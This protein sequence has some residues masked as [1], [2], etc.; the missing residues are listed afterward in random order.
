VSTSSP[1]GL[2][3]WRLLSFWAPELPV[4]RVAWLRRVIYPFVI[5]DA[6]FMVTD[7]IP[8]GDVPVAIY[9]PLL[10]RQLLHLPAPSHVYVRVLFLVLVASALVAASGRLPRL[11]GWVCAFAM[12]DWLSNAMSYSKI[13]HDHFALVLTLFVLP[14]VGVARVTHPGRDRRAGWAIRLIQMGV[15]A[16]YALSA[17]AKIRFGGWGWANGA[18]L[19][20]ALT[21]RGS[22]PGPWLASQPPLTHVLQWVVLVAEF[23]SPLMLWLRGR[24]LAAYVLFWVGFHAST[25]VLLKIH[26]LPLAVC[27]LAFAP[28]ERLGDPRAWWAGRPRA[29]SPAARRRPGDGARPPAASEEPSS[30]R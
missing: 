10:V 1:P 26:F 27:L 20:W 22:G 17:C 3:S 24:P 28:L 8:H 2:R 21:R 30:A 11:A 23:C 5:L 12:L 15:V 7:P 19:I 14:T 18:T 9:R 4:A 6:T 16:S 25:W 29:L 13:D